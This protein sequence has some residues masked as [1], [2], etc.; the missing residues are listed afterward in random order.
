MVGSTAARRF[1]VKKIAP[2]LFVAPF[3]LHYI[4]FIVAP[5]VYAFYMSLFRDTLDQ[6]VAA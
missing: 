6:A 2:Y 3:L 4:A 5:L 1:S